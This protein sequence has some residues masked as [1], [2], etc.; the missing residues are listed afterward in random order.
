MF[1]A[2]CQAQNDAMSVR[3]YQCGTTLIAREE[4]RSPEA[5]RLVHGINSRVHAAV[6][7]G[8]GAVLAWLVF[9]SHTA[10]VVSGFIGGCVG[11][12][13]ALRSSNGL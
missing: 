5:K 8:A 12:W 4:D 11:R 10:T 2:T 13:I 9:G 3:C 1:C 6:G 7:A